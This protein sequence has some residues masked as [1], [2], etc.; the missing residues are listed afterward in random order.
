MK[1][2]PCRE[3]GII[4][5]AQSNLENHRV[6]SVNVVER[7]PMVPPINSLASGVL[8]LVPRNFASLIIQDI[9]SQCEHTD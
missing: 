9:E 3:D 6:C 7:F 8:Q 5:P 2:G 1:D 4:S